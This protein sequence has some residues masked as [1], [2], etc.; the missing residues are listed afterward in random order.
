MRVAIVH[1][2]LYVLGGA[3]RVLRELLRL[4]PNA[5]V[6]TLFD[7]LTEEER[8]WIGFKCSKTSFLQRI[9]RIAKVHRSLLPLMPFAIEQLDFSG[10]DLVISSSYAVAK[11]VITGPDQVHI[12]YVHTPMRY[13][14]DLQHQY[15]S[16]TDG[17]LG[18]KR[19]LA[20]ILLH[21]IRV[22]DTCSSQRPDAIA[23]N[24]AFVARRIKKAF[25][26][27]ARVIH[28]P[29]DVTPRGCA[30]ARRQHFLAAGRLVS[31]K[32]TRVIVDAFKLLPEFKLVVAGT[33]P[34]EKRLRAIAGP[35]VSFTGFVSD[36]EM[37]HLMSSAHALIFA[38]LEDF[39]I[40][41]VEA[42]AE[43]TPVL[44]LGRGGARETVV[45]DGLRRTGM[46]FEEAEPHSIAACINA[47]M[48]HRSAFSAD[49][50]QRHAQSFSGE[51][52]RRRFESLANEEITKK[53]NAI[54][55]SNATSPLHFQ[56]AA[57]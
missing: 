45:A 19:N 47:F 37:R 3:E 31:Y 28:P 46:F 35:N 36:D 25:G 2:W 27:E 57:E 5:D 42:Q 54:D 10:Y 6:F 8:A 24:S 51:Y 13:A 40:V 44:A 1:D 23:S 29:V 38:A 16:E 14:W 49:A 9:P 26:R 41:P 30:S 43:G 56:V 21:R 20:R 34:E 33:G 53:R 4:Y 17:G 39:G 11:G 32:N 48:A 7:A 12:A 22:W 15:L 55:G 50:C 18:V 52:F